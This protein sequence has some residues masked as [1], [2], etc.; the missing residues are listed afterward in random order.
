MC[1]QSLDGIT[2]SSN[3]EYYSPQIIL[4]KLLV[5]VQMYSYH[6]LEY[7]SLALGIRRLCTSNSTALKLGINLDNDEGVGQIDIVAVANPVE[8]ERL[9]QGV[10]MSRLRPHETR[11]ET[12]GGGCMNAPS[13][14]RLC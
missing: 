6:K 3:H 2:T 11:M 12:E 10:R 1:T 14:Q 7:F 13:A 4:H 8:K 5:D 9:R